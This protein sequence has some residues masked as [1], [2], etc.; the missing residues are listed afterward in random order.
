MVHAADHLS[1]QELETLSTKA[2][3]AK[4]TAY[5]KSTCL[6]PKP[7]SRHGIYLELTNAT[8]TGPY[9]KFRVGACILTESGEFVQGANVENAS[10]PV[11][12]CAER[13]AFGNAIVSCQLYT[14]FFFTILSPCL[15]AVPCTCRK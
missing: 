3:A 6:P 8:P 9:S 5:C 10:Y 1:A 14:S 11:G 12:T 4:D 13:V 2:I 15:L 7:K